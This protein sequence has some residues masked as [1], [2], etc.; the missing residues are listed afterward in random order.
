[1]RGEGKSLGG[2][3]RLNLSYVTWLEG[4]GRLN[5]SYS[6]RC[7]PARRPSLLL[8]VLLSE[9]VIARAS[10]TSAH[11]R[12]R[13]SWPHLIPNR[14]LMPNR[15]AHPGLLGFSGNADSRVTK[16]NDHLYLHVIKG[17]VISTEIGQT[18]RVEKAGTLIYV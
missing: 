13:R 11:S 5:L 1:M 3:G 10:L 14:Y 12:L 15:Y 4:F 8:S 2:S 7:A 18:R 9:K 16:A 17:S 6:I